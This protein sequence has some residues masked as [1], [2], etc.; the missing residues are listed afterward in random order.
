MLETATFCHTYKETN[1]QGKA[2]FLFIFIF[3]AIIQN[4]INK[5]YWVFDEGTRVML[6]F[7]LANKNTSSLH[8]SKNQVKITINYVL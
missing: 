2:Y 5:S 8:P 1:F 7:G 4:A 6:T 3:F